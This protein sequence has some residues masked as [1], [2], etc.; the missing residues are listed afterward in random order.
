MFSH[1]GTWQ[2]PFIWHVCAWSC[3]TD[4]RLAHRGHCF[5]SWCFL[6]WS[7]CHLTC[8]TKYMRNN[9]MK[10]QQKIWLKKNS[11]WESIPPPP[12]NQVHDMFL[13]IIMII[14]TFWLP[15]AAFPIS[16]LLYCSATSNAAGESS[17]SLI[18]ARCPL[19]LSILL[20][21]ARLFFPQDGVE[22]SFSALSKNDK[23][24]TVY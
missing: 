10:E 4:H 9:K 24:D 14:T 6:M 13:R 22:V 18:L 3:I 8:S 20:M 5:A 1:P 2:V 17:S 11:L 7:N 15:I 21:A 23:S 19:F 16:V 12:Q